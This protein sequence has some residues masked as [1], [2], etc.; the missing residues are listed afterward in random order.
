MDRALTQSE[1]NALIAMEKHCVDQGEVSLPSLGR[2]LV[3]D[4]KSP[5]GREKFFL[6]LSRGR[7]NVTKCTFQN[8]AR[9][10]IIL[11]RVDI[12]GGDHY[13]PD[14]ERVP[15]PH[16]H[17]YR[18]GYGDKWAEPLPSIFGNPGNLLATVFDFFAF[19]NVTKPPALQDTMV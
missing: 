12:D 15:C 6:D 14:G 16:I 4:L 2:R 13:N 8:R 17:L 3:L 19:C 1:A 10:T 11:V 7:L 5:D 9:S 18:E